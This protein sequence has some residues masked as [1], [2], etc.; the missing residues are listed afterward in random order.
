[1]DIDTDRLATLEALLEAHLRAFERMTCAFDILVE[2]LAPV[3]ATRAPIEGNELLAILNEW[4]D[5]FAG[6][7]RES[8]SEAQQT[9][10][11]GDQVGH[12]N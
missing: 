8:V 5:A 12:P 4:A 10:F 6:G 2:K 9:A 7:I 1:M 11:A 3:A